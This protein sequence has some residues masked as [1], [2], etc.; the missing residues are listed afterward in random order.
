MQAIGITEADGY[1][2]DASRAWHEPCGICLL[3]LAHGQLA[4]RTSCCR[5]DVHFDC[6]DRWYSVA[7][8]I[9]ACVYCRQPPF[10]IKRQSPPIEILGPYELFSA[11]LNAGTEDE[12]IWQ[13]L[14]FSAYMNSTFDSSEAASGLYRHLR[15]MYISTNASLHSIRQACDEW[16]ETYNRHVERISVIDIEIAVNA[17]LAVSWEPREQTHSRMLEKIQRYSVPRNQPARRADISKY[18]NGKAIPSG[19]DLGGV[20]PQFPGDNFRVEQMQ[21]FL[22]IITQRVERLLEERLLEERLLEERLLEE[23]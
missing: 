12:G 20:R 14:L 6:A 8:N 10:L 11:L 1:H 18:E 21:Y 23:L 17:I 15:G 7:G 4:I 9:D 19:W 2:V 16:L 3:A 5:K 13:D 22:A